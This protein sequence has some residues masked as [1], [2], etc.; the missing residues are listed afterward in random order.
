MDCLSSLIDAAVK[1]N[2]ANSPSVISLKLESVWDLAVFLQFPHQVGGNYHLNAYLEGRHMDSSSTSFTQ[3]SDFLQGIDFG[4]IKSSQLLT[5]SQTRQVMEIWHYQVPVLGQRHYE[6]TLNYPQVR[7]QETV[8]LADELSAVAQIAYDLILDSASP[9]RTYGSPFITK[10][11][12]A[13][14]ICISSSNRLSRGTF[15]EIEARKIIQKLLRHLSEAE[16]KKLEDY[17]PALLD[18]GPAV[19]E[20]KGRVT[21]VAGSLFHSKFVKLF[22]EVP[23][24]VDGI[25]CLLIGEGVIVTSYYPKKSYIGVPHMQLNYSNPYLPDLY[26]NLDHVWRTF[27]S[28]TNVPLEKVAEVLQVQRFSQSR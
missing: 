1:D 7:N 4:E 15:P 12:P 16:V 18:N 28:L 11:D 5:D 26:A 3:V 8:K 27:N 24:G 17:N 9:L 22:K 10:Q 21:Q 25:H 23:A 14:G 20:I 19:H 2:Q 13:D 6:I